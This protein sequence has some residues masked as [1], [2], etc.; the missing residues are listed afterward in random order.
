MKRKTGG[1]RKGRPVGVQAQLDRAVLLADEP[2]SVLL[3]VPA[4]SQ[5]PQQQQQQQQQQPA[6]TDSTGGDLFAA[7]AATKPYAVLLSG[8]PSGPERVENLVKL[9]VT[10]VPRAAGAGATTTVL[11]WSTVCISAGVFSSPK[12]VTVLHRPA[13]PHAPEPTESA[14]TSSPPGTSAV[15][16]ALGAAVPG[17]LVAEV[18]VVRRSSRGN[19]TPL[20]PCARCVEREVRKLAAVVCTS[21][22]R[23]VAAAAVAARVPAELAADLRRACARTML[24][25]HCAAALPVAQDAAPHFVLKFRIFC[26]SSHQKKEH[27]AVSV[28]LW[29]PATRTCVGEALSRPIVILDNHKSKNRTPRAPG[30]ERPILTAGPSSSSSAAGTAT[31]TAAGAVALPPSPQTSTG[32][33]MTT[34]SSSNS[35]SS[36]APSSS[37][38]P[39][40]SAAP[41]T[42][43]SSSSSSSSV[44]DNF[45]IYQ[46]DVGA[47]LA[48]VE[49]KEGDGA[50]Y[51]PL[52]SLTAPPSDETTT[53]TT[54]TAF[55]QVVPSAG[56]IAGGVP[57]TV[58]GTGFHTGHRLVFGTSV[59]S[60][61]KVWNEGTL[62]CTLPPSAHAG[63]V[64][65]ALA[66][67][68]CAHTQ[69]FTYADDRDVRLFQHALR[70]VHTALGVPVDA[71]SPFASH[72]ALQQYLTHRDRARDEGV[73]LDALH[74]AVNLFLLE[75]ETGRTLVHMAA[76]CGHTHLV[77]TLL[78][79]AP[80]LAGLSD[81][82]G[83]TPLH[84]ACLYAAPATV[85]LLLQQGAVDT[86]R[87]SVD[88]LTALDCASDPAVH[89]LLD[90]SAHE[91]VWSGVEV[92]EEQQEQ[93]QQEQEQE[94]PYDVLAGLQEW[95]STVSGTLHHSDF[96]ALALDDGTGLL[97]GFGSNG[98][99]YL[100][101]GT[102]IPY[103]LPPGEWQPVPTLDGAGLHQLPPPQS[104]TAAA[105]ATTAAATVATP[106]QESNNEGDTDEEQA[107]APPPR[108]RA[109]TVRVGGTGADG[110]D[111]Y[112]DSLRTWVRAHTQ[113]AV[114]L[115]VVTVVAVVFVSVATTHPHGYRHGDEP[116]APHYT[117]SEMARLLVQ[118]EESMLVLR[119]LT[120]LSALG[121]AGVATRSLVH[122][123]HSHW[124]ISLALLALSFVTCLYH[125]V[126]MVAF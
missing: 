26:Y 95:D 43:G 50:T 123:Y 16:T 107:L 117:S 60:D 82:R 86:A 18:A 81:R 124:K 33:G 125:I 92:K 71:A 54:R 112:C 42:T 98:N 118:D 114:L 12:G 64:P 27:F 35:S 17:C 15:M 85:A 101:L 51:A 58:L 84:F 90:Q 5:P 102:A 80:A 77:R 46:H 34:G 21:S 115:M 2:L 38:S 103:D 94:H 47:A 1:A 111:E 14:A 24:V 57:V 10:L 97:D 69:C 6:V 119:V 73:L 120:T 108:K 13:L 7:D 48:Q 53:T 37:S 31:A 96:C 109:G 68:P 72:A 91:S 113:Q 36:T 99:P 39:Q 70:V 93:E 78:A 100:E 89:R 44:D 110:A 122:A 4:P 76:M 40:S 55:F 62:V 20:V 32:T 45:L 49:N 67:T 88:G 19:V 106:P 22:M 23:A 121:M 105:E 126:V 56:S 29:D 87:Q 65:V 8:E 11:P 30:P 74:G 9:G 28:R 3:G 52:I 104:Q 66:G 61:T 75:D 41:D 25:F 79:R 83:Y 63:T 59:A 116:P